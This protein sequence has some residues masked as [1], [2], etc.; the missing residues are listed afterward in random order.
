[1]ERLS[2]ALDKAKQGFTEKLHFRAYHGDTEAQFE[3]GEAYYYGWNLPEDQSEAVEW[4]EKAADQGHIEAHL[5]L[6]VAFFNGEG[7]PA[8]EGIAEDW[9]ECAASLGDA[10]AQYHVGFIHSEIDVWW[11]WYEPGAAAEW[12]EMAAEQGHAGAQS[13]LGDMY[14]RGEGVEQDDAKAMKWHRLAAD[15]KRKHPLPP[16][17]ECL[18]TV[19]DTIRSYGFD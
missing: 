7:V 15:Q 1:M 17:N 3:L 10:E 11:K 12:L 5:W 19:L 18:G 14:R 4:W 13:R 9:W 6:G 8:N 16:I 2:R